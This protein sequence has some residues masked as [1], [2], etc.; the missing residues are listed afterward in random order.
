MTLNAWVLIDDACRISEYNSLGRVS[1][2]NS[3]DKHICFTPIDRASFISGIKNDTCD[4]ST[5]GE[6]EGYAQDSS[7]IMSHYPLRSKMASY[8]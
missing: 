3:H 8:N 7:L 1:S 4:Q 2:C 6:P 5:V